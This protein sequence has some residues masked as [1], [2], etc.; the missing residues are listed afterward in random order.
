MLL[1]DIKQL[2]IKNGPLSVRE[3]SVL[4]KQDEAAVEHGLRMWL[5]KGSVEKESVQT[6][7]SGCSSC[8]SASLCSDS[9]VF[10]WIA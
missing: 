6:S 4:L 2:L 7:C 10:R 1:S 9:A 3:L 5:D 8:A